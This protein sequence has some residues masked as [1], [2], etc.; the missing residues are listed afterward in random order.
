MP[1][2]AVVTNPR[3][4]LLSPTLKKSDF[5]PSAETLGIDM[6]RGF[7]VILATGVGSHFRLVPHRVHLLRMGGDLG[8]GQAPS[9]ENIC[10]L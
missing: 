1:L 4:H 3:S 9:D 6:G 7:H 2:P 5:H 8:R 10:P